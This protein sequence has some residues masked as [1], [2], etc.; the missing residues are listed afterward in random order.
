MASPPAPQGISSPILLVGLPRSGTTWVGKIFDSHPSTLYL[1]E[2]D[3]AVPIKEIP[4]VL[5]DE[6]PSITKDQLDAILTRTLNVRLTRVT[7][8][9]PRFPKLYRRP[10]VD[11]IHR[12]LAPAF[13]VSS[14]L[15]H[16]T[17]LP[18][19]LSN[20][21]K[22]QV[23]LVW[24][25]V[26]SVGRVGLIARLMPEFRIIHILRHPCGW[27]TSYG[28]GYEESW[29][30]SRRND[31]QLLRL[32][33]ATPLARRQGLTVESLHGMSDL[34]RTAWLWL[35]WNESGAEAAAGLPNVI[36]L[37]YDRLC[38]TPLDL[39][40][41]MFDFAGLEWN[42]QTETF[43]RESVTRHREGYYGVYRDP[44]IS[45]NKWRHNFTSEQLR[46]VESIMNYGS[47]GHLFL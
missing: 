21:G 47:V 10:V 42:S 15:F 3:T 27:M 14:Q 46:L 12:R 23:R 13:K 25:S 8:S 37:V 38:E 26:L 32:L 31:W 6:N 30:T 43:I 29:F 40:R 17:N 2:P 41:R 28:R 16:E 35:L 33:V 22:Q 45:A 7:G 1:H 36:S 19:L 34:E 5:P 44:S 20:S 39:S 9:L 24:K 11:W 4:L 18:D